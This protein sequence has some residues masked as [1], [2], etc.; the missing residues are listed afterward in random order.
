M[1][2]LW[3]HQ[4]H[5]LNLTVK[6]NFKS[7]THAHATGTGKSILGHAIIRTFSH[8]YPNQLMIWLCEQTS[9]IHDIFY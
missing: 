9:V 5:A 4:Q 7:G 1:P 2:S 6:Q 8:L 3:S